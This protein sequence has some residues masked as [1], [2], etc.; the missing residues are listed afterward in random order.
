MQGSPGSALVRVTKSREEIERATELARERRAANYS[1]E[2]MVLAVDEV[3]DD[4]S[5]ARAIVLFFQNE[6]DA[7]A[8]VEKPVA[9][10]SV[11]LAL[12]FALAALIGVAA[13]FRGIGPTTSFLGA[14]GVILL[15]FLL[16][17]IVRRVVRYAVVAALDGLND[18]TFPTRLHPFRHS[19]SAVNMMRLTRLRALLRETTERIR[20][21]EKA[22]LLRDELAEIN[23][24]DRGAS[25][26]V[27]FASWS[28]ATR[29]FVPP[30]ESR[31]LAWT[32]AAVFVTTCI[33]VLQRAGDALAEG[34]R[35]Y[36]MA[37]TGWI[38]GDLAARPRL[39]PR[40]P[41]L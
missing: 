19:S 27:R 7:P 13:L 3:L 5:L 12:L 17:A 20:A 35:N 23:M 16:L 8:D 15:Q 30:Y 25:A 14:V 31:W 2:A 36:A 38:A 37:L 32:V 10:L 18:A 21:G 6:G 9:W 40:L 28:A 4:S 26:L 41:T 22:R 39:R 34:Y 29:D 11:A 24:T 33:V 1:L